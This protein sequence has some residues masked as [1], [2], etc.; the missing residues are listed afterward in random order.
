MAEP[1]TMEPTE[2]ISPSEHFAGHLRYTSVAL[3]LSASYGR[4]VQ[5]SDLVAFKLF[6]D[7]L[8]ADCGNPTDPIE[9]MSIEQLILCHM[10]SGLLHC[11]AANSGCVDSAAVYLSAAARLAGEFRRSSLALQAYRAASA[12]LA[13]MA[14]SDLDVPD[15]EV[16]ELGYQPG[17]IHADS[18]IGATAEDDDD[19]PAILPFRRASV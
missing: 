18:E 5:N 14:E 16:D 4:A 17:E 6:R 1:A 9:V 12:R 2:T 15:G 7:K 19:G 11:K 8:V 13:E 3:V 10:H